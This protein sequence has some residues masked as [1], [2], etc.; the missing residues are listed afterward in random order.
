MTTTRT[1]NRKTAKASGTWFETAIVNYLHESGFVNAQRKPKAGA[2]DKGDIQLGDGFPLV[3]EAKNVRSRDLAGWVAE[4]EV[5][6]VNAGVPIGV[7]WSKRT[8]K[9]SPSE[10]Y[11]ICKGATFVKLLTM[12]ELT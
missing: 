4:A 10:A 7:V 12:L 1:R 9:S 5:E 3:I 8:G 11:V 6:A 2:F